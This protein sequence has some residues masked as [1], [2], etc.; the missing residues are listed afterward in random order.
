MVNRDMHYNH[1]MPYQ[2]FSHCTYCGAAFP[3]NAA[4]PRTCAH[5]GR[6]SFRNPIPVCVVLVP[7]ID[8]RPEQPGLL[9]VRR[10]IP[11]RLGEWAL[12]GGYVNYGE[13]WQAAG[14]REVF[15]ESGLCIDP[16]ELREFRVRSARDDT[17]IIF[18]LADP[19]PQ[20][21]LTPFVPNEEASEASILTP[22]G[23]PLA[24][25]LHSEMAELFFARHSR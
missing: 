16:A 10:A 11:P 24:F 6:T 9:I 7:V 4:W 20:A 18:A 5:C 3:P 17:L 15:E 21:S 13:T 8:S 2:Q 19:R 12:P 23:F 25:T 1:C 14:A 22:P